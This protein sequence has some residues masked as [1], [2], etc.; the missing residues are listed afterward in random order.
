LC[1]GCPNP[2]TYGT[3]RTTPVGKISH[4]LAAEGVRYSVDDTKNGGVKGDATIPTLPTYQIRVGLLDTLDIGARLS[5]L[6]SFGA[7]LKWNFIKSDVFDMAIDPGFQVFHIGSSSN[8]VSESFTEIYGHAPLILG[9][10]VADSVSIVPTVG[11]TYGLSSAT[12]SG[13]DASAAAS[14]DGLMFRGG[15]GFNFRISPKFAMQPE[16]TYLKWLN[17]SADPDISWVV[18]GLGFNFGNLPTYGKAAPEA[19]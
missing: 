4:T 11:V 1:T 8:G 10:N 19:K 6:S 16:V 2:N 13:D 14:I 18:F 17:K 12:V 3:P 5:N 15:L 9:I 7:D